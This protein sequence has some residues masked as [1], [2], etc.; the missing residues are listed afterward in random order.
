MSKIS[1]LDERRDAFKGFIEVVRL[2]PECILEATKGSDTLTSILLAI[3]SWHIPDG[4]VP[5]ATMLRGPYQF[6]EFPAHCRELID[7]IA[8]LL[9]LVLPLVGWDKVK[10]DVPMNVKLLLRDTYK[11]N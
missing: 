8:S 7:D 1:D 4:C 10:S 3:L 6:K 9:H 11:L 5:T 2:H